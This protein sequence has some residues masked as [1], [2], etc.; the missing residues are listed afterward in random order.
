[1]KKLIQISVAIV[2]AGILAGCAGYGGPDGAYGGG[3]YGPAA[4]PGYG[5][6]GGGGFGGDGD[7]DG[8]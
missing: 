7:G 2:I 8:S 1:M 3:G 5:Y 6:G 4:S